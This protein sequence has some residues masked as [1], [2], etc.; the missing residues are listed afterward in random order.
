ML[1]IQHSIL[2]VSP[3]RNSDLTLPK[4]GSTINGGISADYVEQVMQFERRAPLVW[5]IIGVVLFCAWCSVLSG[6]GGWLVGRDMGRRAAH[7]EQATAAAQINLP[8]LGVLVTRLDRTGAAASVGIMR[9][10]MIV[11]IDGMHVQDARDLREALD[12]YRPGD[13][14]RLS[15]LRGQ[16]EQ[17]VMVQL[18]PF[19][20]QQDKPYLGIYY[21]ARGEEPADL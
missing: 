2:G 5:G 9:G 17:Q 18:D 8:P 13:Y 10:D 16:S 3:Q 19:P 7:T 15:V 21:T 4:Q 1:H 14:V 11:A 20:G 6:I 12:N